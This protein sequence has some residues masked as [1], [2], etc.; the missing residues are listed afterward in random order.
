MNKNEA[1]TVIKDT[2]IFANKEIKKTK[3]RYLTILLVIG[4]I[5]AAIVLYFILKPVSVTYAKSDMFTEE[6]LK[7]AV[8][9]VKQDFQSLQGCKLFSLAYNGDARSLREKESQPQNG[10][11]YDEYI[12]IDSVFLS[13]LSGGGAWNKASIYT[14]CWILGRKTGG[15]WIVISRGYT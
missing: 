1:E 11:Q 12:V 14:W 2:I 5:L 8:E 4:L 10:L 9:C 3:K 6:D 7:N 15:E 13:P